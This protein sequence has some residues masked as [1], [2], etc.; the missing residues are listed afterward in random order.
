VKIL[1]MESSFH[2]DSGHFTERII[3]C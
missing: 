3:L 2:L 1:G